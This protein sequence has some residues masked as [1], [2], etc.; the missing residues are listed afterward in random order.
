MSRKTE[1]GYAMAA[2]LVAL[3]VMSVLMMAALPAWRFQARREK[4][5][6]LIFR[7][8]Q[9]ARAISLYQ[10][11]NGT[12]PPSLDV[13]V[14]Q[15]YIRKEYKDPFADDGKFQPRFVGAQQPQPGP[16]GGQRGQGTPPPSG[17]GSGRAGTP[18]PSPTGIP[19]FPLGQGAGGGVIGVFS[20]SK[21]SSIRI[22]KGATRYSDFQ[23]TI[24]SNQPGMPGGGQR[25]PGGRGQGRP[26]M[27][28]G[29][30]GQGPVFPG[31]RGGFPGR[32][33]VGM[34]G[35]RG[36]GPGGRGADAPISF[37]GGRGRGQ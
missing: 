10:R 27:P 18:S 3:A 17:V 35:G 9:W 7:G 29:Q 2:L 26:G 8:E 19:G 1:Q 12:F 22:Y 15:R 13:L 25:G 34:P 11:K 31:G 23:F 24:A 37:P 21:E 36:I 5:A 28:P 20:K 4:E 32:G 14:Q 6:E 30:G 33:G 16:P